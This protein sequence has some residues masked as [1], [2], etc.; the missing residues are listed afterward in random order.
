MRRGVVAAAPLWRYT[1]RRS[2]MRRA[3]WQSPRLQ[4]WLGGEI[5]P[6]H[7]V[8]RVHPRENHESASRVAERDAPLA[9]CFRGGAESA[10]ILPP[11]DLACGQALHDHGIAAR[12]E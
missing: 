3:G 2:G 12:V 6:A 4:R 5:D 1:T 7:H 9:C 10:K 8:C 11:H